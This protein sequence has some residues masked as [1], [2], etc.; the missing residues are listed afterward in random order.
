MSQ[1]R[2]LGAFS[3]FTWPFLHHSLTVY[4]ALWRVSAT[5]AVL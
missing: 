5:S 2:P 3:T 1:L 4:S